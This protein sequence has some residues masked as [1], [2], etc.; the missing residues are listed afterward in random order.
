MIEE[1]LKFLNIPCSRHIPLARF[2]TFQLGGACPFFIECRTPQQLR[3]AV[4]LCQ[5]MQQEFVLLGGGSNVVVSDQ[6]VDCSVIRYV[7]PSPIIER[8]GH[9]LQ[10]SASTLLDDL[11]AYAAREGLAGINFAGG[12]PGTVGGA[13]IGNAGAFGQQIGDAVLNVFYLNENGT[14]M[15]ATKEECGFGYRHSNFKTSSHVLTSVTFRLIPDDQKVLLTE[16]DE[17]LALRRSKHPDY[18]QVP[19]AGSF[20]KNLESGVPGEKRTAAGWFLEQAGAKTLHVGGAGV[21]EKH[22]NIII[23]I[24]SR[25]TAQDV[26]ELAERMA[27]AVKDRFDIQLQREVRFLGGIGEK[28]GNKYFW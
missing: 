11:A 2:T 1:K 25:C 16:R 19:C 27:R 4:S 15:I 13:V 8:N 22:A 18:K 26:F 12:I 24:G 23:K 5:E 6:G 3:Q 10:V 9:D 20:F 14:E 17:I 21:F 7:S 28:S